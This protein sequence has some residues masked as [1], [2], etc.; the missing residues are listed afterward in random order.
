MFNPYDVPFALL[1]FCTPEPNDQSHIS[2]NAEENSPEGMSWVYRLQ[3]TVGIPEG[4][5][6][7][8]N[9]VDILVND[10]AGSVSDTEDLTFWPF[11][12][13]TEQ[14]TL[15]QIQGILPEV[16]YGIRHQGW[17]EPPRDAIA[18]PILGAGD[19]SGKEI[20]L[21][22]LIMGINPRRLFDVDYQ[23]FCIM[24]ARQISGAM[25]T[26]NSI[27][28]E[29]A[30]SRE[31]AAL[32]RDRTNFFNTVSH[33][34]RTP[35]TLILGPVTECLGNPLLPETVSESLDMVARNA[36]RLLK[37]VNSLLDFARVEA[38]RMSISF[39]ETD[40]QKFTADLASQF[41][42]AIEK[43][44]VKYTVDISGKGRSVWVD[45]DKWEVPFRLQYSLTEE[46][47]LQFDWECI[48]VYLIGG[49]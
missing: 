48:Q 22:M 19:A 44:G 20:L 24:C 37:L 27:E 41:R 11:Q 39:Q 10:N 38:G 6:L 49:D 7:A 17:P 25:I 32:N 45:R 47:R 31:L 35:L 46:N 3:A 34:L 43:G 1:Y 2:G 9:V 4:H 28:E 36:R 21:G 5:A 12:R 13:L 15:V 14:Q 30:R 16:L 42:S 33:E 8:P 40:L 18:V 29:A 23:E 26:V